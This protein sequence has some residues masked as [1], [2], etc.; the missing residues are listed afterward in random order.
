LPAAVALQAVSVSC[1]T[2]AGLETLKDAIKAAVWSGEIQAEML[3]VMI[4]A[5]HQDALRRAREAV[6]RSLDGLRQD[7]TLELVALELRIAA[8]AVGEIVGETATENLLD[9][10]FRQFCIGK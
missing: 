3:Q 8:H 7:L 10:I 1:L 9:S 2:G 5:R 4:N 6:L